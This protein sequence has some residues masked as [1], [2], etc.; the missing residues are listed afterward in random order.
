[1][2]FF[3]YRQNNSGGGFDIDESVGISVLVIIEADSAEEANRK[4]EDIGLYFDGDGDCSCCGNRWYEVWDDSDSE[5]VPSYYGAPIQDV[6]FGSGLNFKRNK[7]G[8]EAYVHFA[9][10]K[11]Q[12]YGLPK[13][14]ELK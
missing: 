8:P 5:P 7:T 2:A 6:E 11:V 3:E 10:G 1:M 4:A 13:A 12:G 14:K 9:D